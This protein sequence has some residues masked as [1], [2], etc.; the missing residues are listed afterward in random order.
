MISDTVCTVC[1]QSD[2]GCPESLSSA[3]L[4]LLEDEL[5]YQVK[6][7]HSCVHGCVI[8]VIQLCT[9]THPR[10]PTRTTFTRNHCTNSLPLQSLKLSYFPL[11]LM[12]KQPTFLFSNVTHSVYCVKRFRGSS[13]KKDAKRHTQLSRMQA[14]QD[15][16]YFS[17]QH[18]GVQWL[19]P[20]RG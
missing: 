12:L 4:G 18:P 8:L 16:L 6:L 13:P 10:N 9:G 1:A 7:R 19:C 14:S 3:V 15:P 5:Q 2:L 11:L 20:S 17:T